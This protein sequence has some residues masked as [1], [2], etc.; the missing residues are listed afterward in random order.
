MEEV[1][2]PIYVFCLTNGFMFA[3]LPSDDAVLIL[4]CFTYWFIVPKMK[5]KSSGLV[6][7]WLGIKDA[8]FI[9][10]DVILELDV[11]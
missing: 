7:T 8:C 9:D 3:S 6:Q 4:C 2:S 11:Q 1:V 10:I 5:S